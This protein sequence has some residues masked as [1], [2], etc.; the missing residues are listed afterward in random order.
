MNRRIS[1]L[2]P[3]NSRWG[4]EVRAVYR[5]EWLTESRARHGLLAA[6]LFGTLATVAIAQAGA[7][8]R[9][10]PRTSAA[11]LSLAVL[12]TGMVSVPRLFLSE[13]EQGTFEFL[14]LNCDPSA[15][16]LGKFLAGSAAAIA[17]ALLTGGLF[18]L[19]LDL[20]PTQ[21]ALLML[22]LIG[23]A[24]AIASGTAFGSALAIGAQN[25]WVLSFVTSLPI[26]LPLVW[27][28][29][30]VLAA[31]FGD[32]KAETGWAAAGLLWGSAAA[33]ALIGSWAVGRVWALDSV[34]PAPA[35]ADSPQAGE[36]GTRT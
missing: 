35:L 3:T 9:P 19:L 21:P 5:K 31:G 29:V 25:R 28:G 36:V 17:G 11:L 6:L 7:L 32:V 12:F 23:L 4:N 8:E 26:C 34:G 30:T 1:D 10:S 2:E 20:R 14:R 16:F 15:A 27:T 33:L 22:G 18:T 13:S 24:G